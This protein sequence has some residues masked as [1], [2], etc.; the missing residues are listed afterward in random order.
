MSLLWEASLKILDLF[1]QTNRGCDT[2]EVETDVDNYTIGDST[3]QRIIDDTKA[4]EV[5]Q[6]RM[7][8]G[9]L[10]KQQKTMIYEKVN[11]V[12]AQGESP[13]LYDSNIEEQAKYLYRE[14]ASFCAKG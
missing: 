6:L 8:I 10:T 1:S 7:E 14:L 11:I 13:T 2:W 12:G 5:S 9:I 3:K 4:Q